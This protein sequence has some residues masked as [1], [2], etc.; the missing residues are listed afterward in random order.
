LP[1]FDRDGP[2]T[3]VWNGTSM[4]AGYVSGAASLLFEQE[5]SATPERVT[6]ALLERAT[7]SAVDERLGAATIARSPL[8]YVGPGV[9]AVAALPYKRY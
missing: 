4:A 3:T 1:G 6:T 9:R 8:L 5:P 2:T 7:Q